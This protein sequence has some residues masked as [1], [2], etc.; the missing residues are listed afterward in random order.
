MRL[1]N[2]IATISVLNEGFRH[3]KLFAVS[4]LPIKNSYGNRCSSDKLE[5]P[6][7][8]TKAR[9]GLFGGDLLL[10]VNHAG[11]IFVP[12][13]ER[14]LYGKTLK[15][16]V[17]AGYVTPW[18]QLLLHLLD[19]PGT[20]CMRPHSSENGRFETALL[21]RPI[22]PLQNVAAQTELRPFLRCTKLVKTGLEL[23][24]LRS[25]PGRGSVRL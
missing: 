25:V 1:P 2:R 17:W 15:L 5:T 22:V 10:L 13:L 4:R 18:R 9:Q 6:Q 21:P 11:W 24:L 19:H 16:S 20:S 3:G 12:C 23:P 14:F 7:I 8:L